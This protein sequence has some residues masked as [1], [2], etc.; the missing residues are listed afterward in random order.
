MSEE[1]QPDGEPVVK[2]NAPGSIPVLPVLIVMAA[3]IIVL[4]VLQF[5]GKKPVRTVQKEL[6][7][8]ISSGKSNRI[9]YINTDKILEE[10]KMVGTMK[11]QLVLEEKKRKED[12]SAK[13][14]KY[15]EDAS[16]FQEQVEKSSI[17]ESSARQ[18][19]EQLMLKQEEL[20]QLKDQYSAELS[21]KEYEMNKVLY[22][23]VHNYLE[24]INADLKMDFILKYNEGGEILFANDSLDLTRMVLDGLNKEYL[25]KYP[26]AK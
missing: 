21:E 7:A 3:A 18:I 11:N 10:Y 25:E 14:K 8:A 20:V 5:A 1:F 26:G 6:P 9:A 19:Y 4:F 12:L 24:K 22:D 17:P 23:S 15:E 13:Q 2:K 16:Y